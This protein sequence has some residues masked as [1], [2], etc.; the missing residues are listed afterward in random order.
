MP[1]IIT[2][3][4][5]PFGLKYYRIRSKYA[6]LPKSAHIVAAKNKT[7]AWNKFRHQYFKHA[8]LKPVR[9]DWIIEQQGAVPNPR[10]RRRI[11]RGRRNYKLRIR[12]RGKLR[13]YRRRKS[14]SPCRHRRRRRGRRGKR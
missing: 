8:T 11:K 9:S 5:N 7:Q 4:F 10:R 13:T 2:V 3:G 1:E 6:I 12:V 14:C